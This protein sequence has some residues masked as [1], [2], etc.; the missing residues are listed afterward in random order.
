MVTEQDIINFYSFTSRDVNMFTEYPKKFK[1]FIKNKKEFLTLPNADSVLQPERKPLMVPVINHLQGFQYT[2]TLTEE[3]EYVMDKIERR[4]ELKYY[5]GLINMKTGKGKS[6]IIMNIVKTLQAP[7][8]ILCHNIKTLLEMVDKFKEFMDYEPWVWYESKKNLKDITITTHDSFVINEWQFDKHFDVI[9]YDECDYDLSQQMF[10]ALCRSGAKALYGLTGTPYSKHFNNADMQKIF[11][12]E[13]SYQ[14]NWELR[15][16][17]MI[18]QIETYRYTSDAFKEYEYANWAE[19]KQCLVDDKDRLKQQITLIDHKI[20]QGRKTILVLTERVEEAKNYYEALEALRESQ[21]T[22]PICILANLLITGETKIAQDNKE[23]AMF[24]GNKLN[25]PVVIVWTVWK[26][27][28]WVDIPAIDTIML[29][30]ALHFRW[31]VVQAV[32]RCLRNSSEKNHP[33]LV[34]WQD[35]PILKNQW[36]ERKKAYIK[37]YGITAED[38]KSFTINKNWTYDR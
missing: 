8:I 38:I 21:L 20:Q 29:F 16:Y 31:T 30:S 23:I 22:K 17:N 26:M 35:Y 24:V 25:A 1:A 13:I 19:E 3:Q 6:H 7:T 10:N 5:T 9:I 37:E 28:R 33:L 15:G 2:G 4:R 36:Y 14:Q 32:G 12:K 27:A 11:G 34:D 18:P